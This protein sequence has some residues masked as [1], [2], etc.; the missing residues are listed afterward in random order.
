MD[1]TRETRGGDGAVET[2]AGDGAVEPAKTA[3]LRISK[4][5]VR[6][7]SEQEVTLRKS[8]TSRGSRLKGQGESR[9]REDRKK[10]TENNGLNPWSTGSKT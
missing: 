8:G 9:S 6:A 3:P 1:F 10:P 5:E 7:M 2:R 4:K